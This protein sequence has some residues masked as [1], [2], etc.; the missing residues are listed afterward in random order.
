MPRYLEDSKE[1]KKICLRLLTRREYSQKELRDKLAIKGFDRCQSQSVIDGL[2]EQGWQ[3]DQ[4]FAES[5][6]RH[7]I[8]KGFGP[9][10]IEYEIFQRGVENID[11]DEVLLDLAKD[12]FEI[13][14]QVYSKK[15]AVTQVVTQVEK[16]KRSRFLFQRGFS[17][18][19]IMKFFQSIEN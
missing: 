18:E 8:K 15:Y 10:K 1:I 13:I 3:S 2:I 4:R 9:V 12:W 16:I 17:G 5:Y 6:A 14:E 11:L 19:M 7:R